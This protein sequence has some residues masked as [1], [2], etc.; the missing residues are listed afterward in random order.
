LS[1]TGGI[2][3]PALDAAMHAMADAATMPKLLDAAHAFDRVLMQQRY[4]IPGR[5][6]RASTRRGG[7]VSAYRHARHATSPPL[8]QQQRQSLADRELVERTGRPRGEA[9][10]TRYIAT[11]LLLMLPL[12]WVLTATFVL[13]SSCRR[14]GR[15]GHFGAPP[16]APGERSRRRTRRRAGGGDQKALRLRQAAAG[17]LLADRELVRA[18]RL[19]HQLPEQPDVWALIKSKL[20]VSI[21]LGIWSFLTVP[22]ID[23]TRRGQGGAR[24]FAL[25]CTFVAG[26]LTGSPARLRTGVVLIVLF[27]G[28][29]FLE[30][31]PLRGLT[32][33]N[34]EE[35][36]WPPASPTTSGTGVAAHLPD[37]R[38]FAT[39]TM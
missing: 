4:V 25:R 10:M 39:I 29:S 15:A 32:S 24:R 37:D 31:F 28:G 2:R 22:A 6:G 27:C 3:D 38:S 19:R 14:A 1:N 16:E 23:T 26:V 35:L 34:W 8:G 7:T 13:V 11:R 33:D 9:N 18:L 17:A 21:S 30:W 12:C 20:P 36:S 5:G